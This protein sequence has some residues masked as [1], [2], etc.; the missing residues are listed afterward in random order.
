MLRVLDG[1]W[2]SSTERTSV[3]GSVSK[4]GQMFVA[5]AAREEAGSFSISRG[6][7]KITT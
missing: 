1:R 6:D 3:L 4:V 2:S 5:V 7:E